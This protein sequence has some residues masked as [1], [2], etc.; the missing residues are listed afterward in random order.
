MA[1]YLKNKDLLAEVI[2]SKQQ[3][4]PTKELIN[5]FIKLSNNAILKMRYEDYEDKKDCMQG[6]LEALLK[7]WQKFDETRFSNA[8]AYYT[9]VYKRAIAKSWNDLKK[10]RGDEN[11]VEISIQRAN[12][13]EGLLNF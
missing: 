6:G 13:G 1:E 2:K 7:N 12:D 4:E 5:M 8:F 9:E 11:A 3:G 10:K